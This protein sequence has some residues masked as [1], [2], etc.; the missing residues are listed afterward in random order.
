MTTFYLV[1]HGET[2]IRN[3]IN[4]RT[5]GVHL[6]PEG[7]EQAKKM[8]KRFANVPI[9]RLYSSPLD[10]T[11]D[12]AEYLARQLN[13]PIETAEPVLEIDFGDWTGMTFD[14]L[15]K[16]PQWQYV[17]SFRSGTRIP[18]GDTMLDVQHRFVSWMHNV[19][20]QHVGQR[21]VVVSHG[22]PIRAAITYWAGLHLD[23]FARIHVSLT[24][25]TVIDMDYSHARVLTMNNVGELPL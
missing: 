19:R 9:A 5:P 23:M 17:N 24:S 1:R 11:M 6:N 13:L 10:R 3:K 7:H 20:D 22:D 12:T 16:D 14:D 8:A 15:N 4:G 25:V 21:V 18:G 2:G